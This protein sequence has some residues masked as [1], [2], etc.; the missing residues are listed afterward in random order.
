MTSDG[1]SVERL[2]D[3]LRTLK[4]E[5]RAMLIV[6]L[7]RDLLRGQDISGS[8]LILQELRKAIRAAGQKVPR[9]GDAARLFFAPLEPFLINDAADH[10]RV[11]RIARASLIPMWEWLGRDLIP[12][13]AK[14]LAADINGALFDDDQLKAEQLTRSLHERAILRVRDATAAVNGD[15]KARRRLA[16]EVGTPRALENLETLAG[17]LACRDVLASVAQRLPN[18]MRAFEREHIELVKALLAGATAL[19]TGS[20]A[21]TK[22]DIFRYGLIL[23]MG[24]LA[25]PWQLVRIATLA[26]QSGDPARVAET[27]FAVAVTIVLG[28]LEC[29]VSDLRRELKAHHRVTSLLKAIHD[30]AHGLRTELDLSVDSPWSRQLDAVRNEVSNVLTTEIESAPSRVRRLLRPRPVN[31][32]APGSLLDA[33]DVNEA[34]ML[35]ELVGACRNYA[36]ELAVNDV[37]MRSHAELQH[38]LETGTKVMLDSLRHAGDADRPF[39][40][41]QV[42]AAIRFSR[43]VFGADY[44]GLLAKA[45]EIA[46]QPATVERESVRA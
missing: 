26:A 21:T 29:M 3:Y 35:L 15:E 44:A 14:A 2:R 4:P 27:P 33:K 19:K 43:I 16:V 13:E 38:H 17:I 28:D 11:G 42:E 45:A 31:D 30:A 10:M 24:R 22:A 1:R 41:S 40:Q 20:A 36:D 5:A 39:R 23:V 25:A 6:E 9:I 32:I 46:V 12:A 37:T 34:E 7:E 18:H 8:E